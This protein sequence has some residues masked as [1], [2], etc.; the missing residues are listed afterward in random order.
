MKGADTNKRS[1]T[2]WAEA[3]ALTD[4]TIDTSDIPPLTESF[5][6]RATLRVPRQPIAVTLQVDPDVVAWFKSQG[7]GWERRMHAA[8]RMYVEAHRASEGA[9]C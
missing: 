5:F 8:L 7:D 4:D 9:P 3:D 1:E 2:N 6:E